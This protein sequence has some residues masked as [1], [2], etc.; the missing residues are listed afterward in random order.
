M[1]SF[2][3]TYPEP[4]IEEENLNEQEFEQPAPP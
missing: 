1:R 3:P 4:I 2:V